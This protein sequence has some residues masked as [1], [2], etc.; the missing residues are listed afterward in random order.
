MPW[1]S[2]RAVAETAAAMTRLRNDV[3]DAN[4]DNAV[5]AAR[6]V[7]TQ[8]QADEARAETLSEA[9]NTL[10]ARLIAARNGGDES[11]TDGLCAAVGLLR[12]MGGGAA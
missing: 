6:L 12:R 10:D 1:M 8:Q 9:V 11:L 4:G 2:R 5:L 7:A 3:R